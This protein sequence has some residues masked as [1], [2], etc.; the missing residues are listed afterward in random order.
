MSWSRG[1]S[2]E[3]FFR[4]W[5]RAP[6]TAIVER[7]SIFL[8]LELI[9]RLSEINE[10][11]LLHLDI[12]ALCQLCRNRRFSNHPTICK[13]LAGRRYPSDAE[14][15]LEIMFDVARRSRFADFP[16]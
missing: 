3:M 4:L 16:Q 13:K 14:V 2:S 7:A 9:G 6:C 5:T 11:E 8:A 12:A 10:G 1:I 15:P